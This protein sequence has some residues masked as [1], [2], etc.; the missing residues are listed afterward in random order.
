MGRCK[1]FGWGQ[2][3]PRAEARGKMVRLRGD[4]AIGAVDGGG[5]Q[6]A[7]AFI[8]QFNG[9][10]FLLCAIKIYVFEFVTTV[11]GKIA[12]ACHAVRNDNACEF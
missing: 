8:T 4:V 7:I 9:I 6:L 2:K 3:R 12:D 5:T 1:F 11:K 10:P